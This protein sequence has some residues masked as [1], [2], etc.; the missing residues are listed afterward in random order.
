MQ[1]APVEARA[2]AAP[3]KASPQRDRIVGGI[4]LAGGVIVTLASYASASG[5]GRY[6][7]TTGAIAYGLVRMV[8]GSMRMGEG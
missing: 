6:I 7:V 2:P 8:P 5:G 4:W 3:H 1:T